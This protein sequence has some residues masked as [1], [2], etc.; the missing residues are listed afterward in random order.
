[1]TQ[2]LKDFIAEKLDNSEYDDS[3]L[4]E[5][6]LDAVCKAIPGDYSAI[7]YDKLLNGANHG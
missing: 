7:D 3:E 6:T 2:S 4:D 5:E 1:M